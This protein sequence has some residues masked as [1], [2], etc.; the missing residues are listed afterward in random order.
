VDNFKKAFR[1]IGGWCVFL[2]LSMI[3]LMWS[4]PNGKDSEWHT[5]LILLWFLLLLAPYM[6]FAVT[7]VYNEI[8]RYNRY[9][10]EDDNNDGL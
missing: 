5:T 7:W 4:S 3:Y 8:T 2:L 10:F 6:F 9:K 1:W